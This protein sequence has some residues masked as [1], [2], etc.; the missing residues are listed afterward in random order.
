MIR[1]HG[2]KKHTSAS[3]GILYMPYFNICYAPLPLNQLFTRRI[4]RRIR[5]LILAWGPVA[6]KIDEISNAE[7]PP[8]CVEGI[9]EFCYMILILSRFVASLRNTSPQLT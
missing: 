3:V 7:S 1:G 9:R 2:E 5:H 8:N 4:R 6:E